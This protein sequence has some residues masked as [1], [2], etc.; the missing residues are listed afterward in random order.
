MNKK[1]LT[2]LALQ[3]LI[4]V[5]LFW[6]LVFYGKDEYEAGKE[7]NEEVISTPSH[8]TTESGAIAIT[9]SPASQKLSGIAVTVLQGSSYQ[10]QIS[11]FG[12]VIGIETLLELRTRYLAA[13]AEAG[14][15]QASLANSRRDYE[16]MEQLNR[17]D[18]NVSDRAVAGAE[19]AWK[20]DESRLAAIDTA[21]ASLR[22]AMRQ[23]WGDTL[24]SWATQQQPGDAMQR[25]L[26]H[27]DVL[28]QVS[29]PHDAPIPDKDKPLLVSPA[30]A[31]SQ[32]V[33]ATFVSASPQTDT[34]LQGKTYYYCASADNLRTGMRVTITLAGQ[35]AN[36]PGVVVPA[37]AVVWYANQPWVYQ[38]QGEDK[39]VRHR[40]YTDIE[41]DSGWFN[42]AGIQAGDKVVTTGAQLLLSEEFKYQIKNENED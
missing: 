26:L 31:A 9:L 41:T 34:V 23:Q 19:A 11:S 42:T 7:E 6:M 4:I 35:S 36:R 40:I 17:D 37:S 28:L 13:H 25:L 38:K 15:V 27:Q 12:T 24:A 16:R 14:V 21:T 33:K 3:T 32:P 29:L 18:R 10:A 1:T 5:M 39:F 30:G 20:A 2:I 8:I 22:D